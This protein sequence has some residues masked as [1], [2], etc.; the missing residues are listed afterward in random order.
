[1]EVYRIAAEDAR[2]IAELNGKVEIELLEGRRAEKDFLLRNDQKSADKQI[3]LSRR[4]AADIAALRKLVA[5]IGKADLVRQIDSMQA[6]LGQYQA[7]FESVVGLKKKL[8]LDED[9]GLE[10]RL[11][12][13]VHAI[14]TKGRRAA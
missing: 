10:G 1:M 13:S 4:V 11:R 5:S 12:S 8:G 9:S 6:S 14:E 2:T 3:E 7:R